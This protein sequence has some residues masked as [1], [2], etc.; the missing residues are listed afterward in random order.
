[1]HRLIRP[2][3][4]CS[5]AGTGGERGMKMENMKKMEGMKKVN[6]DEELKNAAGG[7][8]PA[9]WVRITCG[10]CHTS[11]DTWLNRLA[12]QCPNCYNAVWVDDVGYEILEEFP[13]D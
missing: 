7:G 10:Y 13:R 5:A 2:D 4:Q 11:F 6:N 8:E 3:S 12:W 9:R 1:M